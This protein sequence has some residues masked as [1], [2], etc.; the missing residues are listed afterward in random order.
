MLGGP[1]SKLFN[2]F[3]SLMV[4]G[5]MTL[6]EHA[7]EIIAFVEMTMISG[8]DMGCFIGKERVISALRD[9]FKLELTTG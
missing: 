9:R 6:R 8:V 3:K 1:R 7:D 2:K 5:F 4:K